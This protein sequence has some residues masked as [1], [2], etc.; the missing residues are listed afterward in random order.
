MDVFGSL[1]VAALLI[2][3]N[4]FKCIVFH[5]LI[6]HKVFYI[7]LKKCNVASTYYRYILSMILNRNTYT[8]YGK[9]TSIMKNMTDL[10]F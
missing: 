3:A 4:I 5:Y 6:L 1:Q 8:I 10:L 7:L 2:F 9:I